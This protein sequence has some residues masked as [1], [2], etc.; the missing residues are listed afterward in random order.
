MGAC[1]S[2]QQVN[3]QSY[4]WVD[5]VVDQKHQNACFFGE[6]TF[7]TT[8]QVRAVVRA[9]PIYTDTVTPVPQGKDAKVSWL[10]QV[11]TAVQK[12]GTFMMGRIQQRCCAFQNC[13]SMSAA[14]PYC[15]DH[16][17]ELLRLKV[18]PSTIPVAGSGLFAW[19]PEGSVT[20]ET[21]VF[22]KGEFIYSYQGELFDGEQLE[23]RYGWDQNLDGDYDCNYTY[24]VPMW[25][26]EGSEVCRSYVDSIIVRGI[27]AHVNDALDEEKINVEHGYFNEN[28]DLTEENMMM[29]LSGLGMSTVSELIES[30]QCPFFAERD[31]FH[32]EELFLFYGDGYWK[33]FKFCEPHMQD[34]EHQRM[35][36]IVE[37][38]ICTQTGAGFSEETKGFSVPFVGDVVAELKTKP[39]KRV[40]ES[41]ETQTTP[42][43]LDLSPETK[44]E[45]KTETAAATEATATTTTT[46]TAT[47]A[48]EATPQQAS[49]TVAE[50]GQEQSIPAVTAVVPISE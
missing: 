9:T 23:A 22:K 33:G 49:S 25:A 50:E 3:E 48:T 43:E 47:E 30:T 2:V 31:I 35:L 40:T 13:Q 44:T 7:N 26:K 12:R 14:L 11:A 8:N 42:T 21:V 16:T 5:G 24:L 17:T 34:K 15:P 32:G 38:H 41:K 29:L 18:Q 39:V 20:G 27:L 4:P 36:K 10:P 1:T 37:Q 19:G 28:T 45:T 6:T 46:T